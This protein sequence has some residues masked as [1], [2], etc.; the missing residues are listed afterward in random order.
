[1][2]GK[3]F[4]E[5]LKVVNGEF[6]HAE[7]HLQRIRNTQLEVFGKSS[8]FWLNEEWVPE[9]K[10]QGVVKCRIIYDRIIQ[11]I[12]FE[13]YHPRFIRS[14]KLVEGKEID[15]HLK[16][17]DRSSLNELLQLKGKCDEILILQNGQVTDTSYSN[18]VFY[19]G[20]DYITPKTYLLN[21]TKRQYLLKQG[22]IKE[23]SVGIRDILHYPFLYLINAMLDLEDSVRVKTSTIY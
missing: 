3:I 1:M 16:Y 22:R 2:D 17:A 8:A 9:E 20:T 11:Q 15:Y 21:G 10:R 19:D 7:A 6:V 4:I 23:R 18:V 13:V 12:D 14:L 5:S